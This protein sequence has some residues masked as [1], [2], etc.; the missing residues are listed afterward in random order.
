M[1]RRRS[2][3]RQAWLGLI[4]LLI[5]IPCCVSAQTLLLDRG[6]LPE[7]DTRIIG[8]DSKAD[9][10][11][12]TGDDFTIG[13]EG[14]TWVIDRIRVWVMSK[15]ASSMA[16]GARFQG[17]TF[18]GGL[19]ND[20][21]TA[22]CACHNLIPL[23]IGT[24]SENGS[25]NADIVVS[26]GGTPNRWQVDFQNFR[27]SVPGVVKI[28]FAIKASPRSSQNNSTP[29]LLVAAVPVRGEHSLRV[30]TKEG[31][32]KSFLNRKAQDSGNSLALS[33]QVWGHSG[34]AAAP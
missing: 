6:I 26:Q 4:P 10:G 8:I 20:Q 11:S 17:I 14:E 2:A 3:P 9:D 31:G 25:T 16:L 5:L 13:R 7:S 27:W 32:F 28:Q 15:N 34:Q 24:L 29:R 18:L 1:P 30:L 33:I 22:E 19:A 12:L 23:K 21:D